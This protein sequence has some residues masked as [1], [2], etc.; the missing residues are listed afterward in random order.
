MYITF[1]NKT[2]F[3]K[4]L[5]CPNYI[6]NSHYHL[7]GY[8][9]CIQSAH[10][11][12]IEH[13]P[14]PSPHPLPL[15]ITTASQ[16]QCIVLLLSL[17]PRQLITVVQSGGL[18]IDRVSFNMCNNTAWQHSKFKLQWTTWRKWLKCVNDCLNVTTLPVSPA[19]WLQRMFPRALIHVRVRNILVSA[20]TI[21][22]FSVESIGIGNGRFTRL[23]PPDAWNVPTKMFN[24]DFMRLAAGCT[25]GD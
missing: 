24:S 16:R 11:V 5:N 21:G 3:A 20:P 9:S 13:P 1:L 4:Y 15:C 25:V 7:C 2:M 18:H 6:R 23:I 8:Q 14:T 19:C 10:A 17:P 12:S 22:Q